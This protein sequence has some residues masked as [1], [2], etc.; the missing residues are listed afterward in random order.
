M[1]MGEE[2]SKFCNFIWYQFVNH[3]LIKFPCFA[4]FVQDLKNLEN[5]LILAIVPRYTLLPNC[6]SLLN[7]RISRPLC[8]V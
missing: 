8:Y 4:R 2:Q 1:I 3:Y 5:L 6:G 7:L